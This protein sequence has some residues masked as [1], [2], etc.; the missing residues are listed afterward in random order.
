MKTINKYKFKN[1]ETQ[2]KYKQDNKWNDES[3]L[4]RYFQIK[5]ST[6]N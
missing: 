5:I 3:R 6:Q 1:K 4:E 2:K